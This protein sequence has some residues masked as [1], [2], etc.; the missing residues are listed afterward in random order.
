MR[1]PHKQVAPV[2]PFVGHKIHAET[3][4]MGSLAPSGAA[5]WCLPGNCIDG[6]ST[7]KK[8]CTEGSSLCHS[9]VGAT[10]PWLEV[11]FGVA[12]S[13]AYVLIYN[14]LDCCQVC[15]RCAHTLRSTF[16]VPV[17]WHCSSHA[18]IC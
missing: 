6:D 16:R 2:L 17:R 12:R 14:R 5:Q 4:R 10:D 9:S 11:D 1:D 13:V 18:H 7:T 8:H 3:A 15:P